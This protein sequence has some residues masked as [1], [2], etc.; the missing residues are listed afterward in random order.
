M[1]HLSKIVVV[2]LGILAVAA[3]HLCHVEWT[4]TAATL[5]LRWLSIT[6][7]IIRETFIGAD[8]D[9]NHGIRTSIAVERDPRYGDKMYITKKGG[10]KKKRAVSRQW[11]FRN[12][13]AGPTSTSCVF[14]AR[15]AF[16]LF[17]PSAKGEERRSELVGEPARGVLALP[18]D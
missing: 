2:W 4:I 6:T 9:E 17:F 13:G 14:T 10:S 3:S 8:R 12:C 5:L 7:L 11:I 1:E 16:S 15:H 18:L